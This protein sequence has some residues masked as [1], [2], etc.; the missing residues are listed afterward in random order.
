MLYFML[1]IIT[2]LFTFNGGFME[3]KIREMA[4]NLSYE[5]CGIIKAG[6]LAEYSE[7]LNSRIE[8][9]PKNRMFYENFKKYADPAAD[10][11]EI[12]SIVVAVVPNYIYNTP[13]EFNGVYG[14]SYMFDYRTDK[15]APFF[16]KRREFADFLES[17]GIKCLINSKNG[18]S[19][20]ARLA[21]YKAGLGIIRRNN[22]FYTQNGSCNYIE[23]FAI[24]K[25]L[26]NIRSVK[27]KECPENCR[28][29]IDACPTCS[30]IEPY[31]MS[32]VDC[33]SFHTSIAAKYGMG[34]PSI[35]LAEKIGGRLYG[36]DACQDVCPFNNCKPAG[37]EIFPGLENLAYAMRPENIMTMSY[38]EIERTL[39]PKYWYLKKEELWKWK[40]NALTVMMNGYSEKYKAS[41]RLGLDDANENVREF[42]RRVCRRLEITI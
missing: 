4:L 3:N 15:N 8:K 27:L 23:M 9:V 2:Y 16:K 26:E 41:I 6:V 13:V 33:I 22:F 37:T 24:D 39:T 31:V 11:P 35:E 1:L 5:D 34:M 29:C 40:I 30:L 19:A 12:K 42:S 17:L 28:R 7:K 36:C 18:F 25:E 32:A 38:D 14:K 20:P 21:A 10:I